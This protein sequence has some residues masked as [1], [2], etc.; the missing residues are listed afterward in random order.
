MENVTKEQND[1]AS[2]EVLEKGLAIFRKILDQPVTVT[3]EEMC[4]ILNFEIVLDSLIKQLKFI[5]NKTDNELL[6]M[7]QNTEL[8]QKKEVESD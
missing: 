7:L 1:V 5:H 6:D 2:H 3:R 8:L 4:A